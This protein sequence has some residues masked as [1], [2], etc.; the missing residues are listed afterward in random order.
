MKRKKLLSKVSITVVIFLLFSSCGD[1]NNKKS[2]PINENLPT[3]SISFRLVGDYFYNSYI[4]DSGRI[5]S[6]YSTA[7]FRGE[8]FDLEYS[9]IGNVDIHNFLKS[10]DLR[11]GKLEGGRFT[12]RSVDL[13]SFL[14]EFTAKYSSLKSGDYFPDL[15]QQ[16]IDSQLDYIEKK[17]KYKD[18]YFNSAEFENDS[19]V[20]LYLTCQIYF[21]SRDGNV[22]V[23]CNVDGVNGSRQNGKLRVSSCRY[24]YSED[25]IKDKKE[26]IETCNTLSTLL[27]E[28]N[29]GF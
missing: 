25:W 22:L 23:E 18:G 3:S 20:I 14:S 6:T 15:A 7:Q 5:K 2:N 12:P 16:Y 28:E 24:Y 19:S 17:R 4:D 13:K 29:Q 27:V 11:F 26:G 10:V 9:I 8:N 1:K 21:I